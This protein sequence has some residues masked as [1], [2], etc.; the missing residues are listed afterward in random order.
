MA[1][2]GL[3]EIHVTEE[4]LGT[5]TSLKYPEV[6]VSD[7]GLK[8]EVFFIFFFFAKIAQ[9]NTALTKVKPV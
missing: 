9:D 5:I 4:R 1:P 7:D 3:R 8:L 2:K 6:V